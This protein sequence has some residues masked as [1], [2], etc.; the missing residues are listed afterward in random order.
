MVAVGVAVGGIE[1]AECLRG[2]IL[3][4]GNEVQHDGLVFG[5]RG[6]EVEHPGSDSAITRAPSSSHIPQ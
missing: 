4:G 5:H 2:E 3:G 6:E 1:Q